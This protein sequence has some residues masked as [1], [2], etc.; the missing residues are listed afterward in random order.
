MRLRLAAGLAAL[1]ALGVTAPSAFASSVAVNAPVTANEGE[2]MT[3][4]LS[5]AADEASVAVMGVVR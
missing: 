2:S 4:H 5:G 3:V 1:V